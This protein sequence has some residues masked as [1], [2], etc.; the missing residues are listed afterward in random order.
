MNSVCKAKRE[1]GFVAKICS[2]T[3]AIQHKMCMVNVCPTELDPFSQKAP[4]DFSL[5]C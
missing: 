2:Y 3:I 1:T 4:R 5:N